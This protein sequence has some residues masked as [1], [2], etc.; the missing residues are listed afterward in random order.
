MTTLRLWRFA[1]KD[2]KRR[3]SIAIIILFLIPSYFILSGVSQFFVETLDEK[4]LWGLVW[5]ADIEAG[6]KNVSET[7]ILLE[8][9][10]EIDGIKWYVY[11]SEITLSNWLSYEGRNYTLSVRWCNVDDP[12]FPSPEFL[13]EG[14]FFKSNYE[15]AAIID[16]IGL[17]LL[18]D[19]RLYKGLGENGTIMCLRA[20]NPIENITVV[21]NLTLIGVI[22]SPTTIGQEETYLR[23]HTNTILIFLPLA[24]YLDFFNRTFLGG[25]YSAADFRPGNMDWEWHFFPTVSIKVKESYDIEKVAE[26]IRQS[27]PGVV[28]MTRTETKKA[29]AIR[30]LYKLSIVL[31]ISY[32]LLASIIILDIRINQSQISMLKVFGWQRSHI[33]KWFMFKY[34]IIGI[35]DSFLVVIFPGQIIGLLLGF[36]FTWYSL[37][38]YLVH[39]PYYLAFMILASLLLGLPATIMGYRI[40]A[41]SAIRS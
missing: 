4:Y 28:V 41:E 16:N 20:F 23:E 5:P 7:P 34:L 19:L 1:I 37:Y 30:L 36:P 10:K 22:A 31:A 35:L 18:K 24:T 3:A 11:P 6:M 9:L 27:V 29:S 8:K 14:R 25:R 17:Q 38:I 26:D 33:V 32:A 39:L 15:R 40:G 2:L 21:L 13:I 12:T